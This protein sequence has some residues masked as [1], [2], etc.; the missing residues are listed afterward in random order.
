MPALPAA[1]LGML[2]V[3]LTSGFA[4][5]QVRQGGLDHIMRTG[6]VVNLVGAAILWLR[7]DKPIEGSTLFVLGPRHGLTVADLLALLP[8]AVA[9][10]LVI[11]EQLAPW[12]LLRTLDLTG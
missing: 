8:L 9:G 3:L 12:R 7:T 2:V 1:A 10:C 11:G 4:W 5:G 6:L